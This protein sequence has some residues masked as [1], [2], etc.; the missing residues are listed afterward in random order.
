M[1]ISSKI[2]DCSSCSNINFASR[3]GKEKIGEKGLGD[4]KRTNEI[5]KFN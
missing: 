2:P 1:N 5:T 4:N 3:K